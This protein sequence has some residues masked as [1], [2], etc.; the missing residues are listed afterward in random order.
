M[1]GIDHIS[2]LLKHPVG[3]KIPL[4]RLYLGSCPIILLLDRKIDRMEFSIKRY[5]GRN[6]SRDTD[7]FD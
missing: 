3:I 4:H 2:C 1:L 7:S 6:H 5:Q